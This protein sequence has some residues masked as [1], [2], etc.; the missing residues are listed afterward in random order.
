[1][2][3]VPPNDL[4]I[5]KNGIKEE[6]LKAIDEMGAS[7]FATFGGFYHKDD[8]GRARTSGTV[9]TVNE[10]YLDIPKDEIERVSRHE[11]QHVINEQRFRE[12]GAE[13]GKGLYAFVLHPSFKDLHDRIEKHFL[14]QVQKGYHFNKG[15]KPIPNRYGDIAGLASVD[16]AHPDEVLA[17]LSGYKHYL[18]QIGDGLSV[19][20]QPYEFIEAFIPEDLELLDENTRF[21]LACDLL[22]DSPNILNSDEMEPFSINK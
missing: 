15:V 5:E 7:N 11:V 10:K 17:L 14:E 6:Y 1:M 2:D 9:I 19:N 13:G 22:G 16:Y 18:R 20:T 12:L 8:N 3:E 4:E 21:R